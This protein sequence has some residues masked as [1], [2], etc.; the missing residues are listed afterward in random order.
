MFIPPK[1]INKALSEAYRL[2]KEKDLQSALAICE[3]IINNGPQEKYIK[4]LLMKSYTFKMMGR[5]EEALELC[6]QVQQ[7]TPENASCYQ[8]FGNTLFAM[9]RY[10]DAKEYFELALKYNPSDVEWYYNKIGEIHLKLSEYL[11]AIEYF[12]KAIKVKPKDWYSH[13]KK[14][15]ALYKLGKYEEALAC[16]DEAIKLI[17]GD[18]TYQ[19]ARKGS[20]NHPL[21]D[22]LAQ[23]YKRQGKAY[24]NLGKYKEASRSFKYVIWS[25]L[26]D[27]KL[28]KKCQE[29]K[30]L[31]DQRMREAKTPTG[32]APTPTPT[33]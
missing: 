15:I 5:Y 8:G 10:S 29:Y 25:C 22:A 14:G 13:E 12:N 24:F 17:E 27:S 4:A 11:E 9:E 2:I 1:Q 26:K 33:A 28:A 20:G 19:T 23:I 31:S 7:M 21:Y 18:H 3:A 30:N 32:Q 6:S 16:F